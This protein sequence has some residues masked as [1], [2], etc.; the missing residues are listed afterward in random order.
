MISCDIRREKQNSH[1]A[2][3][4]C[5][6]SR[7]S[8]YVTGITNS[9]AAH[10]DARRTLLTNMRSARRRADKHKQLARLISATIPQEKR[11]RSLLLTALNRWA[12]ALEEPLKITTFAVVESWKISPCLANGDSPL[13]SPGRSVAAWKTELHHTNGRL[14]EGVTIGVDHRQDVVECHLPGMFGAARQSRKRWQSAAA[15]TRRPSPS[16]GARCHHQVCG[17]LQRYQTFVG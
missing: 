13:V 11:G 4:E 8:S 17:P 6:R 15:E 3:A 5:L 16:G 14:F 2:L 7:A 1:E 9:I 10:L 12:L